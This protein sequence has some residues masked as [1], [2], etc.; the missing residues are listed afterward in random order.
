MFFQSDCN[1]LPVNHNQPT[2]VSYSFLRRLMWWL[3]AV[4]SVC[5]WFGIVVMALV[6]S[7]QLSYIE[8]G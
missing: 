5:G 7:S 6:T 4:P 8:H 2:S 1:P 3:S